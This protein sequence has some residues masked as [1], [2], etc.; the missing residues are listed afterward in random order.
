LGFVGA[1]SP[2]TCPRAGSHAHLLK[3]PFHFTVDG[4][5]IDAVPVDRLIAPLAGLDIST[6]ASSDPDAQGAV[7]DLLAWEE[8]NGTLPAGAFVALNSGWKAKVN[9]PAAYPNVDA[10]G[11][12]HFPGWR[13]KAE[14]FLINEHDMVEVGDVAV[15][16]DF[17]AS[18]DFGMHNTVLLAGKCGVENLAML[19]SV[20]SSGTTIVVGCPKHLGASAGPT[21]VL[22]LV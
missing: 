3:L 9:D 14:A 19:G 17:G 21:R 6:R 12:P 4:T 15:S 7:D 22:A 8:A 16:P 13:P 5:G 11:V 10:S 1:D 18:T 2:W 20:P